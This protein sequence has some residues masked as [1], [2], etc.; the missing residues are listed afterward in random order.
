MCL[1]LF[2]RPDI[3]KKKSNTPRIDIE[4][5]WVKRKEKK[6]YKETNKITKYLSRTLMQSHMSRLCT[7]FS[8]S[9]CL[10]LSKQFGRDIRSFIKW[11]RNNNNN[12]KKRVSL[13]M[14]VE[15]LFECTRRDQMFKCK[16]IFAFDVRRLCMS[17]GPIKNYHL[18]VAA[19][20]CICFLI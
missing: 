8:S 4:I 14:S 5:E 12:N 13:C 20:K 3:N 10:F 15:L 11:Q 6:K 1:P 19:N 17:M 9:V 18:R 7:L 16:N 2:E